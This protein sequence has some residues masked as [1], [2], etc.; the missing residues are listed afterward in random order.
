MYKPLPANLQDV[1]E[2]I[3]REFSNLP[4]DM[5]AKAQGCLWYEEK[6]PEAVKDRM[7]SFIGEED[8]AVIIKRLNQVSN[9]SD[10]EMLSP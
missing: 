7:R 8:K 1:R 3:T 9:L 6:V 4:E 10:Y 5:V 2:R